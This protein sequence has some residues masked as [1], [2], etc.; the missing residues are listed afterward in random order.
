MKNMEILCHRGFWTKPSEKNSIPYLIRAHELGYGVELDVRDEGSQI[1]IAH[2]I[3]NNQSVLFS[4]YLD[5]LNQNK[6][7]KRTT[8]INIKADGLSDEI[9]R[10]IKAYNLS[11]YFTFDMSIPETLN[12]KNLGLKYF[13]RLSEFE[14]SAILVNNATGIWLDAF[15][16]EWYNENY[17]NNLLKRVEKVCIVSGELHGWDHIPQWTM[18]KR[19]KVQNNLMLCTDKPNEAREYFR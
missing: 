11:N 3:P 9:N 10:L 8:A 18:L 7:K 5:Q 14:K 19:L 4:V 12:Y 6:Y 16:S 2:D 17:I 13:S 15:D 1:V